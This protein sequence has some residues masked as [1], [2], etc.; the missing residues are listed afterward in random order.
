MLDE[1]ITYVVLE[2][3]AGTTAFQ[4]GEEYFA[5]GSV[6]YLRTA[7]DKISARVEGTGTYQPELRD[8]DAI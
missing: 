3:L 7:E 4:R 1:L 6:G 8:D 5:V 2:D